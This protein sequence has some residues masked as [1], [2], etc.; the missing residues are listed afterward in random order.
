MKKLFLVLAVLTLCSCMA[1]T[2]ARLTYTPDGRPDITFFDNKTRN[3]VKL[4]V[5]P[6]SAGLPPKVTY[7]VQ[8]SDANAVALEAVGLA[9][10]TLGTLKTIPVK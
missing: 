5:V 10:E 3:G 2:Q 9:R 6:Q 4:E 8:S 7:T 1:K